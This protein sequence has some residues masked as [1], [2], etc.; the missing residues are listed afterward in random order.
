MAPFTSKSTKRLLYPT[1]FRCL[2]ESL[3]CSPIDL[4]AGKESSGKSYAFAT[5]S[6]PR[7][8]MTWT[9][10]VGLFV[11]PRA[12]GRGLTGI[13][14][15]SHGPI[16]REGLWDRGSHR[17]VKK[18]ALW[19]PCAC[20]LESG[21]PPDPLRRLV[22][23]LLDFEFQFGHNARSPWI[24]PSPLPSQRP[25]RPYLEALLSSSFF[26]FFGAAGGCWPR[27]G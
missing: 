8:C 2:T 16:H 18:K 19:K 23:R 21:N 5:S 14:I 17:S 7:C 3:D 26:S 12:G 9:L 1:R 6:W 22:H 4:H 27:S 20:P 13:A 10:P 25:H 24:D 15:R 11:R